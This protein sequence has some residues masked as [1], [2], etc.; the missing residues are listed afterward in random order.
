MLQSARACVSSSW[1][2]QLVLYC[3]GLCHGA[4]PHCVS[5]DLFACCEAAPLCPGTAKLSARTQLE[6]DG[7]HPPD[8]SYARRR[9]SSVH[10][11]SL[12]LSRQRGEPG[13][14]H[15]HLGRQPSYPVSS[16]TFS[17]G[18]LCSS[19]L[20]SLPR[21]Q[22]S[23]VCTSARQDSVQ[24]WLPAAIGA[25]VDAQKLSGAASVLVRQAQRW[26]SRRCICGAAGELAVG[27]DQLGPCAQLGLAGGSS[28]QL[29]MMLPW[30]ASIW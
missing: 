4:M 8:F 9:V 25:L 19:E 28:E 3:S 14:L 24:R 20:C 30:A 2:P 29:W 10:S 12:Q 5:H 16:G 1:Q 17:S 27:H 6:R 21:T 26:R 15:S 13:A 11:W 7:V 23:A 18:A 22:D